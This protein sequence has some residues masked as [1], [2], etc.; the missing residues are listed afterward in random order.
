LVSSPVGSSH[1]H[2]CDNLVNT[3][4]FVVQKGQPV[5]RER[6]FVALQHKKASN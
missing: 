3:L 6:H 1:N 4:Y 5:A 2:W